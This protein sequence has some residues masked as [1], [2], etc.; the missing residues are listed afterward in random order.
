[1]FERGM[2]FHSKVTIFAEGCHG[3]LTKMLANKYNLREKSEP[4]SYGIGLK[5]LWEVKPENHK[6]GLVEHTIGWPLDKNT[7]GGSF[8]YHLKVPEGEA[9]LVAA[10]F[11]V[12]LDYANPYMSPFR[13]FQRF[14]LHPYVKPLL[15]GG[16]RIAYGARALVEGGWQCMPI[17]V[18][19]GGCLV[20]D[21]AGYLNM[22]RIKGTHNAMKS[23]MLAAEAAMDLI[24]SGEATHDTGVVPSAYEDKLKQSYVYKE[25]KQVR[26]V[27]PSFHT[28]LGLYGGIIYTGI[29]TILR[30]A[31]P[32]TLSHGGADHARLKPAKEC[33][34]IE[35]PKPD[36]VITFDLLSSV[37]LT[38]TNHEADQPPHLT[39]KDD[40]VPVKNNL[41]IY[42]GPEAR[43]CPAGV[44]EYV[45]LETGDGQRL[46]I[47]AQ[48]C[49]HCKTCDIK[50]PSQNIN[51]V[52][53][54]GGG[55]P[56]YNG[57]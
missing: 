3:H 4:Q 22:P 40:T 21:T 19:P 29:S 48:N 14:K 52:V 51:W 46:Q 43:F 47:N 38:G 25:L 20:G 41:G 42:D 28:K 30:G 57:M 35:Y 15:E 37:S 23:G 45:P 9:P 31:E 16:S 53:P 24:I 7:Y 27:R 12:G 13:E 49:I 11:V 5:E 44:Y 17:P 55:G 50:D 36:G 34:P 26:N 33:Q 39:L 10:G 18:F 32:W 2:E 6:P 54:E 8:I 1:M 56:A